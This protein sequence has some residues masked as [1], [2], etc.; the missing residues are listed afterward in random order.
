VVSPPLTDPVR[1]AIVA[2]RYRISGPV[3]ESRWCFSAL[4]VRE[5]RDVVLKRLPEPSR[6]VTTRIRAAEGALRGPGQPGIARLLDVVEGRRETWLVWERAPGPN[7]LTWWAGVPLLP[8][9]RFADRWEQAAPI[10][11]GVW[12]ALESLH[13]QQTAHLDL[14]PANIRADPAG[15]TRVVDLGLLEGLP[16]EEPSPGKVERDH[17]WLAPELLDGV[18]VGRAADQWSLG[19]VI[20]WLVTGRKPVA[21]ATI[22]A[23]RRGY[24]HGVAAPLLD[25]RPDTPPEFARI[26]HR[27][28]EWD[29]D[30]RFPSLQAAREVFGVH[31]GAPIPP[32]SQPWSEPPLPFVGREANLTFYKRR[33]QELEQG[34]GGL[35]VVTAGPG[36]GKSRLLDRFDEM[37]M[38]HGGLTVHRATTRPGTP[39]TVLHGWFLAPTAN[40]NEPPPADLAER[41]LAQLTGP[42]VVLLDAAEDADNLCSARIQRVAAIVARGEAPI[43]VLLIVAGRTLPALRALVDSGER[44]AFHMELPSLTAKE[45]V[46][47]FRP[48]GEDA[49]VL[50]D[51]VDNVLQRSRGLPDAV[52]DTIAQAVRE[53]TL[54]RSGR[55]WVPTEARPAGRLGAPPAA[56][57]FLAWIAELGGSAEIDLLLSCLP[58]GRRSLVEAL[59]WAL[60]AELLRVRRIGQRDYA[61]LRL[62]REGAGIDGAA[63]RD[64]HTRIARWI[65]LHAEEPGFQAERRAL[66]LRQAGDLAAAADAFRTAAAA[67]RDVG[68]VS[69]LRRLAQLALA[70]SAR[71][72]G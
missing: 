32:V 25:W 9:A 33:I 13:R 42:T 27:M 28:L 54:V 69:E 67:H 10:V 23:L 57:P 29:P 34:Q 49:R 21:G 6:T 62:H 51:V 38:D 41:A 7:L 12:D 31:L 2:G 72:G 4:D 15:G 1:P 5:D 59:R 24:E 35:V 71:S 14:K 37:A 36:G 16:H 68:A 52:G 53:G 60:D 56:G 58:G 8:Q 3:A 50:D 47:L 43:P 55:R 65:E 70:L 26:V 20:Y 22:A 40:P 64:V 46:A 19:A 66:H 45:L 48:M 17:G 30:L 39:H 63:T 18:F 61:T 11:V 44:R